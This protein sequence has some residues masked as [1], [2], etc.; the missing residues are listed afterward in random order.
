MSNYIDSDGYIVGPGDI[1][2]IQAEWVEG[3]ELPD[4][5]H[6][7]FRDEKPDSIL[8]FAEGADVG[9]DPI[10]VTEYVCGDP[11]YNETTKRWEQLWESVVIDPWVPLTDPL[12]AWMKE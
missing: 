11:S 8:V 10:K 7:L 12:P 9:D 3:D 2:K 1:K 6:Q 4:G 5:Y